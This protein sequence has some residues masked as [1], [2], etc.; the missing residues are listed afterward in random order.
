MK[1][2]LLILSLASLFALRNAASHMINYMQCAQNMAGAFDIL[3]LM[4]EHIEENNYP[5]LE[6]SIRAFAYKITQMKKYCDLEMIS[7]TASNA[8]D[9]DLCIKNTKSFYMSLKPLIDSPQ[10]LLDETTGFQD[11]MDSFTSVLGNCGVDIDDDENKKLDEMIEDTG[12]IDMSKLL[13]IMEIYNQQR[14]GGKSNLRYP[15]MVNGI[16]LDDS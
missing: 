8:F 6:A 15:K 14:G 1:A 3:T 11:V 10:N 5:V 9:Q 12:D 16:E 13:P 2:L 4:G 7:N